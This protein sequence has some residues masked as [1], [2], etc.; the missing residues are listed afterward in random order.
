MA[1]KITCLILAVS[2]VGAVTLF[3]QVDTSKPA[4]GTLTLDKKTYTLKQALTYETTIDNEDAIVVVLSGQAISSE[5][6]DEARKAEK[7]GGD[8]DFKRHAL[9]RAGDHAPAAAGEPAVPIL[10]GQTGPELAAVFC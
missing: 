9:H 4:E 5:Q 10:K 8:P 3:S 1:K 7:E 2:A 6:F